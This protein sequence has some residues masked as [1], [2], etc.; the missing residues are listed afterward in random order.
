MTEEFESFF[1]DLL[2]L[3]NWKIYY[4]EFK[5]TVIST[6]F[7]YENENGCYLYNS[8][9]NN[10]FN[11]LNPGIV[12]NDMIINNLIEKGKTFFDFLKGTERYKYDLGGQSVQLYDLQ[13]K[14]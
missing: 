12:I 9:R 14:I 13:I 10:Q 5:N 1:Y 2:Q 8:S 3:E 4:L 11:H 7:C 6:A